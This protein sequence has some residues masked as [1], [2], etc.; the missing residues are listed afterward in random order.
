MDLQDVAYRGNAEYIEDLFSY[1]EICLKQDILARVEK[2]QEIHA[3]LSMN[4]A[5]GRLPRMEER[6]RA[7]GGDDFWRG[8]LAYLLKIK[9]GTGEEPSGTADAPSLSELVQKLLLPQTAD[10]PEVYACAKGYERGFSVLFPKLAFSEDALHEPLALDMRLTDILMGWDEVRLSGIEICPPESLTVDAMDRLLQEQQSGILETVRALS[11]HEEIAALL[12]WGE[13]GAGKHRIVKTIAAERGETVVFCDLAHR[14]EEGVPD[15]KRAVLAAVRE[16]AL[17]GYSLA[18]EGIE[19]FEESLESQLAA[20][21]EAEILALVPKLYLIIDAEGEPSVGEWAAK[22]G[23]PFP[24]E[25][26]RQELWRVLLAEESL[27]E[28]VDIPTLANTFALTPGK[29]KRALS[30]AKVMAVNREQMDKKM[31]YHACYGQMSRHLSDKAVR[32]R[33][34][35]AWKDLKLAGQDKELLSDICDC[36][37]NRHIVLQEWNFKKSVPYG[38]GIS[39]LFAGPP[40]TGKTMAAQVIANELSMEL[41]RVDL[42]QVIDKYVGETEKNIKRIFDDAAKMSCILFFDEADAIFHKRM[43]AQGANERFANIESSLLLQC[44]EDYD[45]ITILATNNQGRIDFAFMRRFKFYLKFTEPN[46]EERYEIWKSVIPDEAPLSDDVDLRELARGFVFT[47]AII[48]NVALQAAYLAAKRKKAIGPAEIV[49]AAKREMEK[50]N[51]T[52]DRDKLGR[53]GE[54]L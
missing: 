54:Y 35:F 27:A 20:W 28:D 49:L 2:A 18:V 42:S 22:I 52:L 6:I 33:T 32:V 50:D 39:C 24:T 34:G 36:V 7:A 5:A 37:R 30:A 13:D 45:G 29:M 19:S 10:A 25:L 53:L 1:V 16:C 17:F 31:L 21:L 12:L 26:K 3:R 41:Y 23:I 46:E 8:A 51:R 44:I 38:A 48:K 40:G 43:E 14:G 9:W 11:A 15:L 47:G 4:E